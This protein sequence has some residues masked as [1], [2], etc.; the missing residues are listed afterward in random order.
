M[1]ACDDKVDRDIVNIR[2]RLTKVETK[3]KASD[4]A[5]KLAGEAI[6]KRRDVV[7]AIVFSLLSFLSSVVGWIIV[8]Y[9]G[10]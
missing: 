3:Q 2:E 7:W 4:D 6:Q 10:R 9:K 8:L 1:S 5:L